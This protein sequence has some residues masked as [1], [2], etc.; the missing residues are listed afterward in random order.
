AMSTMTASASA[1]TAMAP[2]FGARPKVRAGPSDV[3]SASRSGVSRPRSSPN[4][5][6]TGRSVAR[7]ANPGRSSHTVAPVLRIGT[8]SVPM[9]STSPCTIASHRCSRSA[10]FRRGGLTFPMAGPCDARRSS[11]IVSA[12]GEQ[13]I[14][15][16]VLGVDHAVRVRPEVANEL[17]RA[18]EH[19]V[20]DGD[21][22]D[23]ITG[24][25]A[26]HIELVAAHAP[27]LGVLRDLLRLSEA[28]D[29]EVK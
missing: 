28:R 17:H 2:F 1:P 9:R 14:E 10:A 5:T 7:P 19:A 24:R 15:A 21:E 22:T 18:V 23:W 25:V 4:V 3:S 12:R 8:W 13:H 11:S 27:A 16:L 26:A 20:V 29:D 6:S